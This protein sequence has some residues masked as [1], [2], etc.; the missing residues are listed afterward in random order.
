MQMATNIPVFLKK[1]SLCNQ[2]KRFI[3]D[4][5]FELAKSI[6]NGERGFM[7][8]QNIN[9]STKNIYTN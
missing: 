5:V 8:K 2:V 1:N 9:I 6:Q 3:F 7:L 4:S